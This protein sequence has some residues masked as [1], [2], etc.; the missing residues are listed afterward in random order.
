[1]S[2]IY[3]TGFGEDSHR[4]RENV[5]KT[6]CT[7]GGLIYEGVPPFDADSDGDVALHAFC[8]AVTSLTRVPILGG[9][10]MKLCREQGK[11][12]SRLYV[13]EAFKALV[14]YTICHV[15]FSFTGKRPH[16]QKR[17]DELR[18]SLEAILNLDP[19]QIGLIYTTGNGLS[20][21]SEG[22]GV[23]CKVLLSVNKHPF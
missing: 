15:V 14:G 23:D 5:D 12:D 13:K 21:A 2:G 9:I 6:G 7:I 22:K 20:F 3:I 17:D 18:E 1:M 16:F 8:Q 10:A 19:E 4:F 11:K